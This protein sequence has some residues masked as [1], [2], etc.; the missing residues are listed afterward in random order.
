METRGSSR[1]DDAVTQCEHAVQAA[2]LAAE[3]QAPA[4]LVVATLLHDVGHLLLDE[5]DGRADFLASDR[6]HEAA[7]ARFLQRWFPAEVFEPVALHAAAKRYL[8]AIDPGYATKL[9]TAS[10]RSLAVQGGPLL[11]DAIRAF[12]ATPHAAA[13]VRLRRWDDAGKRPGRRVPPFGSFGGLV[14]A[15]ITRPRP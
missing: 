15:V 1:Y 3:A 8:V 12:E 6:Q 13:A 2:V 9:S 5:H 7:G 14:S 10:R 4:P 11:R